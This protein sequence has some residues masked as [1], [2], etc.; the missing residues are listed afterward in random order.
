M[1]AWTAHAADGEDRGDEE[2]RQRPG[3]A[4]TDASD[5]LP[6]AGE[7]RIVR[8][9]AVHDARKCP[10]EQPAQGSADRPA[11]DR[12]PLLTLSWIPGAFNNS[13]ITGF[14]V[15]M[16]SAATGQVL[17]TTPCATTTCA[18]TTPG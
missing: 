12:R 16:T 11:Q 4:R 6:D 10:R 3:A 9:G 2:F 5:R 18:I 8:E 17:S 1:T 13:P 7:T 15:T 14:E